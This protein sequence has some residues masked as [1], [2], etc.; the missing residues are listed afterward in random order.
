MGH[1]GMMEGS[2]SEGDLNC[3]DLAQEVS[4]KNFTMQSR[5]CCFGEECGCFLPL[6]KESA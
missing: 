1:P 2:S 6:S 3:E 4:E 5:D